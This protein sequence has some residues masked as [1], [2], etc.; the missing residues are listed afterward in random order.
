MSQDWPAKLEVPVLSL[1]DFMSLL[2]VPSTPVTGSSM[3]GRLSVAAVSQL[4]T[5]ELHCFRLS[6]CVLSSHLVGF[7]PPI[8]YKSNDCLRFDAIG[9][10]I[11]SDSLLKS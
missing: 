5:A 4:F 2:L 10:A 6:F 9:N 1:A 7:L 3:P 11:K 8:L